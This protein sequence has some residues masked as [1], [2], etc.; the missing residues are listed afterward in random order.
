LI[1]L[2]QQTNSYLFDVAAIAERVGTDQWFDA[3]QW[4]AYKL[5][6]SGEFNLIYADAL[7]RLLGSVLGKAKKCLVLDLDNTVWGGVIG[8]DGIVGIQIGQGSATGEAFLSIQQLA[9]E[10][11]NRGIILAVCSKNNDETARS[12]FREN[13]DMLLKE[14]D[15]A[16]FQ[17]NW[18][19]K[20]TN[21]EAI[22]ETLNIGVDSLVLLDDNPAERAQVRAALPSV[23]VPELPDDPALFPLFLTSAGYFEATSFSDDD[24][25]RAESYASNAQRS[26]VKAR[27]RDL[28]DYLISLKMELESRPFDANGLDRIT[29]LINKTNQF[30]LTTKR[31]TISEIEN[32]IANENFYTLQV[33]LKDS[34]GDMGMI[35]VV[36]IS[37]R[38]TQWVIEQWL[39]SCR[40]LGR[41]VEEAMLSLVIAD[42]RKK[43]IKSIYGSFIPTSKNNM[44]KDHY[45]NLGF[46]LIEELESGERSFIMQVSA[47]EHTE[48]PMLINHQP[49]L[50]AAPQYEDIVA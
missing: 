40:V 21:L 39:M 9:L 11:K 48:L 43:G 17:A 42:A 28:G 26:Q 34:F 33:R 38:S 44:V 36:I 13:P 50:T 25:L 32:L 29:Q 8:D 14:S 41:K 47:Y 19:D 22:A 24:K 31:A 18:T 7:G 30:N 45:I 2:A 10:L 49:Q 1:E 12:G 3:V 5:P 23:G 20:A 4:N 15:I 16:V 37:Q 27:S 6:F 46:E 35:G